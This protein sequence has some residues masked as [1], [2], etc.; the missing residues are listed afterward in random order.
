VTQPGSGNG[1]A[2]KGDVR[3]KVTLIENKRTDQR[4]ITIKAADLEKIWTE[5]W[6]EGRKPVLQFDLGGK[7]WVIQ[8]EADYLED[9]ERRRAL[10]DQTTLDGP[11]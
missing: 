7:R 2:K 4:Q 9:D 6:S 10:A 1:W 8:E 3:T 11:G 5:A